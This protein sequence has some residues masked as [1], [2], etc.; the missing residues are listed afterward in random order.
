M[1]LVFKNGS[2]RL[3]TNLILYILISISFSEA[4]FTQPDS[5]I[6][7]PYNPQSLNRYSFELNN[8]Y[9]NIDPSG[10]IPVSSEIGSADE[11]YDYISSVESE[12]PD[13]DANQ[14][15]NIVEKTYYNY[16]SSG[17][18][19][20]GNPSYSPRYIYTEDRGVIDQK[21]FFTNA[22]YGQ[23]VLSRAGLFVSQYVIEGGQYSAG[24][25]YSAF[26]YE[27][28][29]S[30]QVGREFGSSLNNKQPLS[31]QYKQ[32]TNSLKSQAFPQSLVSQMPKTESGY[33]PSAGERKYTSI[34]KAL[35]QKQGFT[36]RAITKIKS[37]FS[38]GK[39]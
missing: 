2:I 38:R 1:N 6:P 10:H 4:M 17:I 24:T 9:N 23:N 15:L 37:F 22:K 30:N 11:V 27:D 29:V 26:T 7:Q 36:Q 19:I 33:K 20:Q 18:N 35:P 28:L 12:N 3:L 31:M 34:G 13:L 32:F 8:P 16:G 39:K 5:N 21:H 14:V 25:D